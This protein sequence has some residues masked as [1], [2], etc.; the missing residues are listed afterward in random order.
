MY[1][2]VV[3]NSK[4]KKS[5]EIYKNDLSEEQLIQGF[6][7]PY[8]TDEHIMVQGRAVPPSDIEKISIY[9]SQKSSKEL[10]Q[11]IKYRDSS[12]S[13]LFLGG[14]SYGLQAATEGENVSDEYIKGPPGYKKQKKQIQTSKQKSKNQ[15]NNVFVVHGHDDAFKNDCESFLHGIGIKPIVL[16]RQTDEGLTVIEKFEKHSEVA[17]AIVL[18]S[19]DDLCLP[20]DDLEKTDDQRDYNFRAR[21]NVIFELGY[22]IGKLG[23]SNVVCLYKEGVEIPSDLSGF[24]YKKVQDDIEQVGFSLIKE[25]KAAGL[26]VNL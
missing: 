4:T 13:V 15:L 7:E 25:L 5:V 3:I 2:H 26:K 6:V 9:K 20:K 12:S 23:R 14:P 22:F 16:H 17:F 10:I 19:P 8:E 11:A 21:Q 18:L 24:I 1:F